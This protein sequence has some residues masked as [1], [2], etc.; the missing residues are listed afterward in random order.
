MIDQ[1]ICVL[2]L[3]R[4]TIYK[5]FWDTSKTERSKKKL[6][7]QIY[8]PD[9]TDNGMSDNSSPLKGLDGQGEPLQRH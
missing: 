4:R 2:R 5:W 9:H 3:T 7:R 8:M 1:L 6:I